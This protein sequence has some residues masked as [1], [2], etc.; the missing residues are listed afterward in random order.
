MLVFGWLQEVI[1]DRIDDHSEET[2]AVIKQEINLAYF[3]ICARHPWTFLR[4]SKSLT[5]TASQTTGT[6]LPADLC[7]I[8]HLCNTD[9]SEWVR[10]DERSRRED[11]VSQKWYYS[12]VV[13]TALKTG[14]DLVIA[15]GGTAATSA[16]NL[17]GTGNT[18]EF[19]RIGQNRGMYE[20]S[21]NADAGKLTLANS[22]RDAAETGAT[23][24][25]RPR[26]T[27]RILVDEADAET[28]TC[29]YWRIP[30]PLY[31]DYD[32]ILLPEPADALI[33]ACWVNMLRW[34][35]Y[36]V[37]A[38]RLEAEANLKLQEMQSQDPMPTF[39]RPKNYRRERLQFGRR[40]R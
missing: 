34:Q 2:L 22:Y 24:E 5:F 39:H 17:F 10:R 25:I 23:F 26:G 21:A 32:P 1:Q 38:T 27:K 35:K 14:T 40:R 7:D 16:T 9:N 4:A 31:G 8:Y 6:L 15:S 18:G 37:D 36:D 29:Y 33:L 11:I 28:L 13:E 20:I 3:A 30:L 12:G 19:V